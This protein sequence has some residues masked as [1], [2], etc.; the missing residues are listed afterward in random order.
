MPTYPV[1]LPRWRLA[2]F[3][4][5]FQS[6]FCQ[7]YYSALH[8]FPENSIEQGPMKVLKKEKRS[9]WQVITE[10]KIKVY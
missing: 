9:G 2:L 3:Q 10:N 7:P 4:L 5:R 6:H 8:L 1:N